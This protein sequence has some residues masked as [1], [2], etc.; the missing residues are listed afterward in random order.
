MS[1]DVLES[2]NSAIGG[3]I[4]RQLSTSLGESEDSTRSAVRTAGPSLLAG[5]MQQATTPSGASNIFNMVQDERVDSGIVAKLG[6]MLGNAG[7]FDSMR[8]VGESLL[9]NLFGNRSGALTN[10]VSQ[11]SGVRPNSALSL[12]SMGL[13]LLLGMLRKQAVTGGLNASGLASL[14]F[15]QR[16]S[17][18]KAGLDSRITSVLGASSLSSLLSGIPNVSSAQTAAAREAVPSSREVERRRGSWMP[19]AIA[20]GIAVMALVLFNRLGTHPANNTRTAGTTAT[21]TATEGS[22]MQRRRLALVETRVYFNSG[23]TAIGNDDR[24]KIANV[25]Q[26][27]K[28]QNSTVSVTGYTDRTGDRNQNREIAK[29]RASAVRDVLV[30]EGVGES[31]IV[32]QPPAEVTGTGTDAEARRVDI[33]VR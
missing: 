26:S 15:S 25:A 7:A 16:G 2:L 5:L 18:E 10:A 22:N 19:W 29:S 12:L 17:L 32:M 14:L 9:G 3:P 11:I 6:S 31:K 27:A 20:A 30:S 13:P 33:E 23:E 21:D 4:V 24:Q 28:Q 1:F 8:G